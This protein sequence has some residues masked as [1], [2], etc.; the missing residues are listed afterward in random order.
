MSPLMGTNKN[1]NFTW[2]M[3]PLRSPHD[4]TGQLAVERCTSGSHN[5][6][7]WP[8]S[9]FMGLKRLNVHTQGLPPSGGACAYRGARQFQAW[10][11]SQASS[12]GHVEGCHLHSGAPFPSISDCERLCLPHE[13]EIDKRSNK[14]LDL[15]AQTHS[16]QTSAAGI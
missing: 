12:S 11:R 6:S 13:V 9:T 14:I 3:C 4:H 2:A 10:C 8:H 15:Q 5:R 1:R 7:A 16:V